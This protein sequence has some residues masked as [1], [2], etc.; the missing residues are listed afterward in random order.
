VAIS[1]EVRIL[2]QMLRGASRAGDHAQRMERFY[3]PQAQGYDAFRER[4]LHGRR[5]LIER[6]PAT[7]G[8]RVIE[9]GGGT[10][11]NLEFFGARLAAL[12]SMEVVDLCPA[13]LAVA[14]RRWGDRCN[15]RL[16]LADAAEYR[17]AERADCVYLSYVLTMVPDW[18]RAVDNAVAMLAPGGILGV[19]DFHVPDGKLAS[20]FWRSWFGHDGVWLSAE[21]LPHLRSR[22]DEVMCEQR[23]G[24]LPY[25]PGLRAP[26]YLFVGRRRD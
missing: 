13:L 23:R 25:V 5:E 3:A 21:H 11:R 16:V 8:S 26:Y 22:L 2:W 15:V 12:A 19:V 4:L 18:R 14:R 6:L 7:A 24:P 17:P 9:L 10:G 1:A 20:R